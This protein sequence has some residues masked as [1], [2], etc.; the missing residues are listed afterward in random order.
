MEAV[1]NI[2][3]AASAPTGA[4][5]VT[6]PQ[7]SIQPVTQPAA[8]AAA[9]E[10]AA[11][12]KAKPNSKPGSAFKAKEKI[13][14]TTSTPYSP[15]AIPKDNNPQ[16]ASTTNTV[17]SQHP[18]AAVSGQGNFLNDGGGNNVDNNAL[19]KGSNQQQQQPQTQSQQ[20]PPVTTA[21][22]AAAS[23]NTGT[24][25]KP[26][27]PKAAD[28]VN[29]G[30]VRTGGTLKVLGDGL[31]LKKSPDS[32]STTVESLSI[33]KTY[34]ILG[35]IGHKTNV[36]IDGATAEDYWYLIKDPDTKSQG[37]VFG[38]YA[39]VKEKSN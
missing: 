5:V 22:N 12:T 9:D 10:K 31:P 14:G 1:V 20:Q 34:N 24:D 26:D 39:K 13:G 19:Y 35:K 29:S 18:S 28:A 17:N 8:N 33:K 11:D 16:T 38:F 2:A 7:A 6:T 25:A 30:L 27:A 37:W 36:V 21:A 3:P 15:T 4:P 23:K 32:G